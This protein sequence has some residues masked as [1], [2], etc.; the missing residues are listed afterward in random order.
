MDKCY[1]CD[2]QG[3]E[4][5]TADDYGVISNLLLNTPIFGAYNTFEELKKQMEEQNETNYGRNYVIKE[6]GKILSHI[7]TSAESDKIAVPSLLVTDENY[8]G[9]GLA[10]KVFSKIC[11]DV[12]L[13]GKTVYV[14]NYSY[15]TT[16]LC[17]KMG[18]EP[19]CEIGKLYKK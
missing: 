13:E 3:V 16:V 12:I 4:E 2:T 8:R 7:A 9:R 15:E 18:F 11:N 19:S 1:D 10:V 6:N 5:A 17:T 14:T